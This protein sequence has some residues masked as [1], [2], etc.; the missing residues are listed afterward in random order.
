M[1]TFLSRVADRYPSITFRPRS[2]SFIKS[3]FASADEPKKPTRDEHANNL[4]LAV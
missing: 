2:R 3:A 4:A 1:L